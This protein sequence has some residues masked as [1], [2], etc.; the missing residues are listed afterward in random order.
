MDG[1][2]GSYEG[3]RFDFPGGWSKDK[4]D[5]F[6]AD[7]RTAS[8]NE[9][10][11]YLRKLLNYRKNNPVMQN[12]KMKQ[13]IPE[14]GFYVYFRYN[15]D[16]TVMVV[17]NNNDKARQ[18]DLS[19]FSEMFGGKTEAKEITSDQHF[20]LNVPLEMPTKTVFVSELK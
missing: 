2:A 5:A 12:G 6:T 10:F 18:L 11:N 8:E 7:G 13:F 16:K 20:Q 14:N 15:A 4:R 19:R 17:V 3:H 1:I 9:V